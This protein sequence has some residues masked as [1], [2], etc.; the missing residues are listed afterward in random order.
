MQSTRSIASFTMGLLMP[1]L[2]LAGCQQLPQQGEHRP[3][4][5]TPP[6]HEQRPSAASH[7]HF[8]AACDAH[9]QGDAV[10]LDTPSGTLAGHCTL[11]FVPDQPT[12]PERP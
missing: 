8:K 7:Q 6:P 2:A 9:Q 1:M 3:E 10:H 12:P 4:G 5:R 11:M